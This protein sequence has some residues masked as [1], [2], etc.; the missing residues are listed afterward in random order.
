[1]PFVV[2][3]SFLKYSGCPPHRSLILILPRSCCFRPRFLMPFFHSWPLKRLFSFV[4]PFRVLGAISSF[5]CLCSPCSLPRANF[6]QRVVLIPAAASSLRGQQFSCAMSLLHGGSSSCRRRSIYSWIHNL[7]GSFPSA[8]GGQIP[9]P[10]SS[11]RHHCGFLFRDLLMLLHGLHRSWIGL[12][13]RQ[14]SGGCCLASACPQ[15][16]MRLLLLLSVAE[17]CLSEGQT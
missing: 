17:H 16:R 14:F 10:Q 3:L 13:L 1:M 5:P 11:D 8:S 4:R 9:V 15:E 7:P 6:A 12:S 2:V